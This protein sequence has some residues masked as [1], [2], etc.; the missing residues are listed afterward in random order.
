M[1]N[2]INV[3]ERCMVCDSKYIVKFEILLNVLL[4]LDQ[5]EDKLGNFRTGKIG[6]WGRSW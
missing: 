1:G 4:H 6:F 3:I 5:I 2:D